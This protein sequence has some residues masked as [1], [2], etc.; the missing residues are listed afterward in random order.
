MLNYAQTDFRQPAVVD[1]FDRTSSDELQKYG[2]QFRQ[3]LYSSTS[4][5]VFLSMYF[6]FD[7]LGRSLS[8]LDSVPDDWNTYGSP[9]P[10]VRSIK[11]ARRILDSLQSESLLPKRVL[12]SAE[13][14]VAFVYHSDTEN[15]AVIESLNNDE[16]FILL[17]DRMGNSRTLDWSASRSEQQNLLRKLRDHLRGMSLAAS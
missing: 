11:T 15:R 5:S 3:S 4:Q 2:K 1:T 17:Y 7:R 8:Q 13:G 10:T 16:A 9:A 6:A 14:G 12:P